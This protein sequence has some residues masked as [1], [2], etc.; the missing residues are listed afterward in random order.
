M[1]QHTN[2]HMIFASALP[3]P[4]VR[5]SE[6]N[7]Y[8][9]R[10]MLDNIGGPNSEMSAVSLYLYNHF[11][12]TEYGDVASVFMKISVVEMRH[13]D[14]FG[15]LAFLLG[16]NPRLWTYKGSR[17]N[18]WTPGYNNYPMELKPLLMNALNGEKNAI[19]KY[20]QQIQQ[21]QDCHIV[22]I[23]KRIILDEEIHV[24]IFE[25][26]YREFFGNKQSFC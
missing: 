9:G 21:I 6:K 3:Y 19:R 22:A 11:I 18:Y 2:Q 10:M 4:P 16:E 5:I 14:L 15:Q 1:E 20:E 17:M 24:K 13:L 23:L 25:D 26:L 8:Y 7:V 12:G